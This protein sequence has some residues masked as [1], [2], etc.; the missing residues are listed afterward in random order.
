VEQ[1]ARERLDPR[2]KSRR[3]AAQVLICFD[4]FWRLHRRHQPHLSLFFSN[5][6][7]SQ[8]HRFW[9]D[10][11]PAY[12][13]REPYRPDPVYGTFIVTAMDL[14]DHGLGRIL[15]WVDAAPNRTLV[16]ASSMG[17]G[18]IPYHALANTYVL[19]ESE[20]LVASLA[21]PPTRLGVAMYPRLTLMFDDEETARAAIAPIESARTAAGPLFRDLRLIGTTL[22]FEI[23]YQEDADALARQASWTTVDGRSVTA[24][25]SAL[26]VTVRERPGG[27]NTAQHVPEGIFVAYGSG[28]SPDRSR[29]QS[30]VL[31]AAPSILALLGLDPAPSMTGKPSI[32]AP[33][34]TTRSAR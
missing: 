10:W 2:Y 22:S 23:G 32:F 29:A 19:E 18:P 14:F 21:L 34:A 1:L 8:M 5:H 20:R 27:G 4:V 30:S 16:V 17:Q 28:A 31:D 12:A 7:A 13:E 9:G 24:D 3:A 11:A 6:V 26:G 33:R 25:I 15:R